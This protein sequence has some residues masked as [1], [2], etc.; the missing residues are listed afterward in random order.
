[1]LAGLGALF[2]EGN[3]GFG[4]F[5]KT[6]GDPRQVGA[7]S[8][9]RRF[10]LRAACALG[11]SA[12]PLTQWKWRWRRALRRPWNPGRDFGNR[13]FVICDAANT[14]SPPCEQV[15]HLIE[16]FPPGQMGNV[17]ISGI[18]Q[19]PSEQTDLGFVQSRQPG[20]CSRPVW[21]IHFLFAALAVAA[22]LKTRMLAPQPHPR[23]ESAR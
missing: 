12:P 19:Q 18:S 2:A 23:D 3:A 11:R 5:L 1:L 8:K 4:G 21:Q 15:S 14:Q 20:Y 17:S 7:S 9:Q 16:D 13:S 22:E 10:R 6:I